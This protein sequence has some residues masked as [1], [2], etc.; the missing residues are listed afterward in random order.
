[1]AIWL[2]RNRD[3]RQMILRAL[4]KLT[5]PLWITVAVMEM[6][7]MGW[8][9]EIAAA[10]P[11]MTSLIIKRKI[12]W[13]LNNFPK[14]TIKSQRT[15][16]LRLNKIRRTIRVWNFKMIWLKS[17]AFIVQMSVIRVWSCRHR[18]RKSCSIMIKRL[19]KTLLII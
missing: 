7:I 17:E 19:N 8:S 3:N 18:N 12:L 13:F 11:E 16:S 5:C 14:I 6:I 4:V 10:I 15:T 2:K 9:L 1:M